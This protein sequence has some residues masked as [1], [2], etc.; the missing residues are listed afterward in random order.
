MS[1]SFGAS[2]TTRDEVLAA[3]DES[4][5]AQRAHWQANAAKPAEERQSQDQV[6]DPWDE[7]DD[8]V[9][10]AVEAAKLLVMSVGGP[11]HITLSG[12]GNP[13]HQNGIGV[14]NEAV[15]VTVSSMA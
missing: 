14:T 3:L 11:Y 10:A 6:L 7:Q 1:W 8:Q 2:G 12:H 9:G 4:A 13:L 5:A 15:T